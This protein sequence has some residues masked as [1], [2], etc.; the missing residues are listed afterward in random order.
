MSL[1]DLRLGL[2]IDV[3]YDQAQRHLQRRSVG[4]AALAA[5]V[6]VVLRRFVLVFDELELRGLGEIGDREHR[7]EHRLQ[8][9]ARTTALRRV[10][11]EE[12]VVGGLL[13]LDQVR[14][15]ADF[16]DVA[17]DFANPF[18][19]GECLR[20]VAPQSVLAAVTETAS[21]LVQRRRSGSADLVGP[22]GAGILIS[23]PRRDL[24]L[25]AGRENPASKTQSRSHTRNAGTAPSRSRDRPI[26]TQA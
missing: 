16:P 3:E 6:D 2:G 10:H 15:R 21:P 20:H 23:R 11:H 7:L 12:L 13:H 18:A 26:F 1:T 24:G 5:L 17:K 8:T 25:P 9:L 14:H 4:H 19:A 22:I